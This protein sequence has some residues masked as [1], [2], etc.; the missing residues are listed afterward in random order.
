MVDIVAMLISCGVFAYSINAIGEIFAVINLKKNKV[1]NDLFAISNF[2]SKKNI[3]QEL[4]YEVREFLEFQ[5]KISS[6]RDH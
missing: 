2:M 4:Q 5:W 3:N 6:D 1:K